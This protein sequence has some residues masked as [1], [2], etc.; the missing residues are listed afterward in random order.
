MTEVQEKLP[1]VSP[2]REDNREH[3]SVCIIG[4]GPSGMVAV[5]ALKD[6]GVAFD[7]FEKGSDIGGIWRFNNDNGMSSAYRTLHIN[8]SKW[9]MQFADFPM[10]EDFPDFG[11]HSD[12][13]RYFE[14]Y[15]AEFDLRK[16]ITFN[17]EV[18]DVKPIDDGAWAVTL[19]SGE[20]RVYQ[21][22]L[23]A[24]G[25]HWNPRLPSFPG[26]FNG[27]EMHS[28]Y[29]K[30]PE[31]FEGKN[32]LIVGIGNSSCDIAID[33]CRIA[34]NV[35]ISTR[36]SAHV[37]PKYLFGKPADLWATP[38]MD[39]YT[40]LWV[41]RLFIKALVYLTVG[42]QEKY[43]LPRPDHKI[44]S[45]HP[46]VSE[47]LLSYIGHGRVKIKPDIKQLSG[48]EVE[49]VDDSRAAIDTIIYATG[50]QITF[51]F[52]DSEMLGL[53]DNR[54]SL[55]RNVVHPGLPNLYF[56]G[57]LQPLGAIMPLAEMQSKWIAKVFSGECGLPSKEAMTDE[58]RKY[59]KN[60]KKRYVT[61]HRHTIQVD[62]WDYFYQIKREMQAGKR[63]PKK[64]QLTGKTA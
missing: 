57:L 6:Q 21:A 52:M 43:G 5:K 2:S 51:P 4:A 20:T 32:V 23:V 45:E 39:A 36:R 31:D 29:Y 24:N 35:Y 63:R 47:E 62:F 14:A 40:P 17:T 33:L 26:D 8:S 54:I 22:V 38:A 30:V 19:S 13:L 28:H 42:N 60:M 50:Y 12:V 56:I 61:S 15:V 9:N 59:H 48:G 27:K 37:I 10:P 16:H 46:T 18:K 44:L 49:F 7:C 41:K 1:I 58:I 64:H 11:H 34:E 25:H 53:K 3:A 55:Y